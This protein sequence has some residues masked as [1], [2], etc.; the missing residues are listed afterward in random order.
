MTI[1]IYRMTV[2]SVWYDEGVHKAREFE[3][4]FKVARIGDIR[5]TRAHLAKRGTGYFQNRIYYLEKRWV[6]LSRI[7][8]GFEREEP[9]QEIDDWIRIEIRQMRGVGKRRR[10]KAFGELPR[11]IRYFRLKTTTH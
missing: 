1:R 6:P 4:H 3:M 2:A 7:R 8:I 11:K 5:E 10:W 9:A